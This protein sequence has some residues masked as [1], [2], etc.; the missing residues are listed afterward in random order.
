MSVTRVRLLGLLCVALLGCALWYGLSSTRPPLV[1]EAS[2]WEGVI[3]DKGGHEAYQQLADE[4]QHLEPSVQHE[5]AHAFGRA[6]Y[7]AEG[8][9]G[10]SVCDSRFSF[11]CFHEFLGSA[12]AAEGL[13]VVPEL[14]E[15]CVQALTTS[16]LSCQ[17]GIG[18]GVLAF[19]GYEDTELR[20][21]LSVCK[22]LP[23][24]DVI[25]G[26]YGGVFMEYNMRTMLGTEARIRPAE[27]DS[28]LYPCNALDEP[29]VQPCYFWQ[30]QWWRNTLDWTRSLDPLLVY[31]RMGELCREAGA[32]YA[33]AC[34]EGI[35]NNLPPD[36]LFEA[37]RAR[38]LCDAAASEGHDRIY[39]RSMAAN[40]LG[41][42]GSGKKGDAEAVCTD[43]SGDEKTYCLAYARNT[44]NIASPGLL[45]E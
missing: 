12:I 22:E 11:G 39:C 10:L 4:I 7:A 15:G 36:A 28:L 14:N 20:E 13:R 37:A 19:L 6:L 2:A 25:G 8:K 38:D 18:H 32:Q 17:H 16:P 5:R 24:N 44:L 34:F 35:G 30:S 31:A 23:Y 9:G 29:Y 43:L 1:G 40:S 42:G 3:R 33:R 21:A 27:D 26:C 45:M 41:V